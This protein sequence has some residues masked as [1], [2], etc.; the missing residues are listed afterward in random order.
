MLPID[1]TFDTG[2]E[3]NG[4]QKGKKNLVKNNICSKVS[5]NIGG[6]LGCK[7]ALLSILRVWACRVLG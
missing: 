5:M 7:D 2:E 1:V 6:D 3:T 4:G